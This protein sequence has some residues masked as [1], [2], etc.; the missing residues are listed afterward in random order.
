MALLFFKGALLEDP[1]NLLFRVGEHMQPSRQ[2]RFSSLAG[3]TRLS[4]TITAYIDQ[5]INLENSGVKVEL[6]KVSEL[7]V[8]KSCKEGW[9]RNLV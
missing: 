4:F 5:A 3:M 6:K 1:D 7:E 2:L 8:P 9:I